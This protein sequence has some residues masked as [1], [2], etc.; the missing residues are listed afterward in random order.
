M[1][2]AIMKLSRGIL[3]I[4]FPIILL[5]VKTK[6]N[7]GIALFVEFTQIF[8]SYFSSSLGFYEDGDNEKY[9]KQADLLIEEDSNRIEFF[10]TLLKESGLAKYLNS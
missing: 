10:I 9:E 4:P 8:W 6:V 2:I 5:I 1:K 7:N 3:D